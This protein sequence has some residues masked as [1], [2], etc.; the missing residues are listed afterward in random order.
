MTGRPEDPEP[1]AD[2]VWWSH[3]MDVENTPLY[4]FGYGLSYTTFHYD[5][6]NLNKNQFAMGENVQV[7]VDVTNTGNYDGK[8]VVQ[9]YI[10]DLYGSTVRPVREL[11]GFELVELKKGEKRTINFTLTED[12]LGFYDNHGEYIVEPGEFEVFVGGNSVET[13][14]TSFTLGEE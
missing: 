5:N 11:K 12:E 1:G 7:S 13:L 9:L 2:M 3:Y 6:L 4:P 8:E 14:K 10:R